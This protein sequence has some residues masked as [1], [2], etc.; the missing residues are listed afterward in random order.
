MTSQCLT[1]MLMLKVWNQNWLQLGKQ[2]TVSSVNVRIQRFR[3]FA[4]C[5]LTDLIRIVWYDVIL[6][7]AVT[8]ILFTLLLHP[9]NILLSASLCSSKLWL[10]LGDVCHVMRELIGQEDVRAMF[11]RSVIGCSVCTP[12]FVHARR[13]YFYLA[14]ILVSA[15]SL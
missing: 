4:K 10:A 14:S 9:P 13:L 11:I 8:H 6:L 2:L 3:L 7:V 15:S 12:A 1:T 5:L